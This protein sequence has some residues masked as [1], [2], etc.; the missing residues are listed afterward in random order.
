MGSPTRGPDQD[1]A[2]RQYK[3]ASSGYD[4][5]MRPFA[6]LQRAAI[7]RLDL[8]SGDTVIDVACGTGINFA[9]IEEG[10][11]PEGKIIG[12]DLS[13]EML[14]QA[15]DRVAAAGWKNVE[16]IEAPVEDAH[17]HELG[18]AALFSFTHDVLQ[19]RVA[20]ANIV[21]HLRPGARVA[22][23]GAKLSGSWN[24]LVNFFVRRAA[25]QYVTTFSGLRTPWALLEDY[26]P[27]LESRTQAFGGAH[28][29]WGSVSEEGIH[30]A[31]LE[32]KGGHRGAR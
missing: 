2:R 29:A 5:H 14:T 11:G 8:S 30:R 4:R 20:V 3:E 10:I 32:H 22:S 24:F 19:S 1:S 15:R 23:V 28:L 31:S 25:R 26:V 16:L 6:R 13:P 9:L 21:V 18:D 17:V 7:K 12:I 27:E